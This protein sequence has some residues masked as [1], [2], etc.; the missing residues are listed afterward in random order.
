MI[1]LKSL[2]ISETTRF[3]R[4]RIVCLSVFDSH[5]YPAQDGHIVD[6]HKHKYPQILTSY[7]PVIVNL[8]ATTNYWH[9][10]FASYPATYLLK[11]R[12]SIHIFN[13]T[14]LDF[15]TISHFVSGSR[16]LIPMAAHCNIFQYP[17]FV[18]ASRTALG[19]TQPPI[20]WV[21]G[22]FSLEVKWPG[23]EAD[24]SPPSSAEVKEWVAL[25]L[26]SAIRLH[27]VVLS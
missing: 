21:P 8:L 9:R 4:H 20:Q 7:T 22:A 25:Y 2:Q 13:W 18:T 5:F 6:S 19:S 10:R 26:H 27:G 15:T 17:L 3:V 16:R 24:R 14:F 12:N 1:P 23:R 11:S